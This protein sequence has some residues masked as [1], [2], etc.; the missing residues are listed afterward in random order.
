MKM[1]SKMLA[2]SLFPLIIL[3][4]TTIFFGNAR[5]KEVVTDNIE[6]GLQGAAAAVLDT[7]SYADEG[8]YHVEDGVLYKGEFN[9]S[10]AV[11]IADHVKS[12]SDMDI[13]V[14]YGDIRYMT[15]V[16][17]ESGK[18]AVGTTA[19][20]IVSEKVLKGNQEYFSDDVNVNGKPYFAI[21]FRL[22][23]MEAL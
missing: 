16:M 7:I 6:N 11:D 20:D 19:Q 3:G 22:R 13:T 5:I 17:D 12:A 1:Q 9:I 15:S 18:R 14:F 23:K 21:T 2:M 10:E 4:I 8:E